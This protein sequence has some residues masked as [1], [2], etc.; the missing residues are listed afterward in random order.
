[1]SIFRIHTNIVGSDGSDGSNRYYLVETSH[2][3]VADL[4]ADLR[5]GPVACTKLRATY[6]RTANKMIVSDR[7]DY[8]FGA[9]IVA[10]IEPASIPFVDAVSVAA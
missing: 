10:R 6:D 1:M 4:V 9:S 7:M 8:A 3:C 5:A 2:T